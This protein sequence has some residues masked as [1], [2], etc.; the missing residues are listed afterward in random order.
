VV[1]AFHADPGLSPAEDFPAFRPFVTRLS[2]LVRAFPG[3]VVAIHGDS[4]E[5]Q[6]DH[7]LL[8][9]D[10]QRL[11]RFTRVVTFGSPDI[12]WVRAVVDRRSG[13]ATFEPRLMSRW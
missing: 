4:H 6:V 7:P 13:E 1:I 2:E 10:G 5:Q 12:G 8:G 9:Y 3:P 11:L